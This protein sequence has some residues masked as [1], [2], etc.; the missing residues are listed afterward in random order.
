M[1]LYYLSVTLHLLAAMLW[2]GGMF[3]LAIV[4]APEIRSLEDSALRT[5]LFSGLGKRFRA[6]G[7]VSVTVLAATGVAILHFRGVLSRQ[8]LASP[9]FWSSPTGRALAVKL[10]LVLT[11]V[12]LAAVHDLWLG[13]AAT[14]AEPGTRRA[15]R[16]RRG[17][18]WLGRLNA[19]LGIV[20]VFVAVRLSRGG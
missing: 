4:G 12:V 15:I 7:W 20:L 14:E 10:L 11:M 13:P 2:L 5:R 17:A 19:V 3:F 16:L 1:S 8:V 9:Y 6:A 18:A